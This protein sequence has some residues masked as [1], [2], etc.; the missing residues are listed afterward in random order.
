[1]SD[2]HG[3]WRVRDV[4]RGV[5]VADRVAVASG[6]WGRFRGLMLR[7]SLAPGEGLF[8]ADSSIHMFFMRFAIDAVFVGAQSGTGNAERSVVA[9]RTGLRPWRSLVMPVR[10]AAG[11][12]ELAAGT[13]ADA[14]VQVGDTL[15]FEIA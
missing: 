11:V 15:V 3:P 8:L 14:G 5:V 9:V 6:F 12:V 2:P 10:G 13:L 7:G 1:M 4:T